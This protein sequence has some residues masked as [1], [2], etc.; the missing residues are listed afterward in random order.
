MSKD[1]Y[2][3]NIKVLIAW[4]IAWEI[5]F[6]STCY[7]TPFILGLFDSANSEQLIFE[8]P[9]AFFFLFA[10]VPIFGIYIYNLIRNNKRTA[11]L[12]QNIQKS[13]MKPV[14]TFNSFMR[15]FLF[16]NAIGFLILAM[17]LPTFGTKKEQSAIDKL[18]LVICLDISSSMNTKDIS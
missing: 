4:S 14:S 2:I 7:F 3:Y 9:S 17:A 5:I 15:Y 6:W 10:I 16:R 11:K 12:S 8:Q 1:K 18:E 13:F